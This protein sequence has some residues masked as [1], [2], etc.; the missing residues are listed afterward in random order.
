MAGANDL[1][2]QRVVNAI[3]A[4]LGAVGTT[5][6][7]DEMTLFQGSSSALKQLDI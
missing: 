7:Y 6:S 3:N 5:V 4:A 1:A 2:M